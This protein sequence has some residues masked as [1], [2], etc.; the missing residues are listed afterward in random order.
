[1]LSDAAVTI[2]VKLLVVALL[3]VMGV[4][5]VVLV[6]EGDLSAAVPVLL[7]LYVC[8][9]LAVGVFTER[10]FDDRVQIAFAVGI[11]AWGVHVSFVQ[12]TLLGGVL[13]L[14]GSYAL[15]SE[16]RGLVAG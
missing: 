8:I 6:S 2:L 15:A 10:P 11:V 1:M 4:G 13:V 7:G 16:L 9:V 5:T 3:G 12:S 14:T